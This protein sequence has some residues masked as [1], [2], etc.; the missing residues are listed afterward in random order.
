[1]AGLKSK[2]IVEIPLSPEWTLSFS[3]GTPDRVRLSLFWK[4]KEESTHTITVDATDFFRALETM[5]K[6]AHEKANL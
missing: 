5:Q 4:D 3:M 6:M 2:H 1:M